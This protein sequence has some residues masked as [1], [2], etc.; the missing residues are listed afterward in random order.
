MNEAVMNEKKIKHGGKSLVQVQRE[1]G[2][3]T[4]ARAR[5]AVPPTSPQLV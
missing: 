4:D 3:P 1:T 2:T 5:P